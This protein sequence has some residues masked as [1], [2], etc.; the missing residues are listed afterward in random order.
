MQENTLTRLFVLLLF[1]LVSLPAHAQLAVPSTWVNQRGSIL[2][3]QA[4]DASTGNFTGTYVNNAAG[5]SC[6]GQP[7]AMA[8]NVAANKIDFYVNWT[9]PTAPNCRTITIWN[10]RVAGDKIPTRWKLY[11]VGS[12]WNFHK[13]T[14]QDLF[15]RR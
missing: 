12:D 13:M 6:R 1:A 10:G 11:Y 8:G 14:G 5:F 9:S 15:T 7:Y 4:I 2:S 3:I